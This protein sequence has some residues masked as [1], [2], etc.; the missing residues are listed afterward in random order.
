MNEMQPAMLDKMIAVQA[1]RHIRNTVDACF[2]E[3][4]AA[5]MNARGETIGQNYR[6]R[7]LGEVSHAALTCEFA[8]DMRERLMLERLRDE[9]NKV[10]VQGEAVTAGDLLAVLREWYQ[11]AA[12]A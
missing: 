10:H 7:A 6:R 12:A 9:V 8:H 4:H 5:R 3:D 11:E 1:E 2:A